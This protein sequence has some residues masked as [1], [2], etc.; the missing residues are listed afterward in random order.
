[1]SRRKIVVG[2]LAY[3]SLG[4]DPG[5]EIGPLV[6]EKIENVETPFRVEFAR[7]SRTRGGAPTL[8]PVS[9]GGA[10]VEAKILVLEEYLSEDDAAGMLW[11][12][13]TRR[14]WSGERYEPPF[15]PGVNEVMVRRLENFE[16]LDVVLYV[17]IGAN[18]T[19][20]TPRKLA[21]L[22]IRSARSKVGREKK[23][24][25]TY[26]IGVKK[27]S[28]KTPLMPEYEGEILRLTGAETIERA[29]NMLTKDSWG[30]LEPGLP[31]E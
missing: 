3:G 10:R 20:L 18:I 19:D 6:T 5:E 7:T 29:H 13:E 26:L 22:A 16:R 17:E 24:G 14:E 31:G 9:K 2:I 4:D 21:E 12:R 15:E 11:R 30:N 8:V 23:D 27:N 25:I 1:M 28:V